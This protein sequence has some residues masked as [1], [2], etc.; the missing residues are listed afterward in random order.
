M[1]KKK[2]I[3]KGKITVHLESD[4]IASF[5]FDDLLGGGSIS[6]SFDEQSTELVSL[7]LESCLDNLDFYAEVIPQEGVTLQ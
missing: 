4:E 5:D 3:V 1:S 2:E 7:M 6:M